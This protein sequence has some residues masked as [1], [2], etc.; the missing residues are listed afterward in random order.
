MTTT[1]QGRVDDNLCRNI[2][3]IATYAESR[4]G[5]K[6]I[7]AEP[8]DESAE[9]L[10]GLVSGVQLNYLSVDEPTSAGAHNNGADKSSEAADHVHYCCNRKKRNS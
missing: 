10:Q 1:C 5:V 6:T 8:K 7:P 2:A 9:S 4:A 3:K